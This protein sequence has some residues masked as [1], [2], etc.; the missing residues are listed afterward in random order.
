MAGN[1]ATISFIVLAAI[2]YAL[3]RMRVISPL[4]ALVLLVVEF[5]FM[6]WLA[7]YIIPVKIKQDDKTKRKD[8]A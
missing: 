2:L 5:I 8:A 4:V 1:L 7:P 3:F 6:V